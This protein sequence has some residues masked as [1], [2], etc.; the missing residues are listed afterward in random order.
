[1]MNTQQL[2]LCQIYILW[3]A[4]LK[5]ESCLT[6]VFINESST[7]LDQCSA[8]NVCKS[9]WRWRQSEALVQSWNSSLCSFTNFFFN[10]EA[11]TLTVYHSC[12]SKGYEYFTI[13]KL[14]QLKTEILR[15]TSQERLKCLTPVIHHTNVDSTSHICNS[16]SM[17]PC[18]D[19]VRELPLSY[20]F[21]G[22]MGH[23]DSCRSMPK[24][25]YD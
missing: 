8:Q 3:R 7:F 23:R 9:N 20:G 6:I 18:V 5:Q 15:Q 25:C 13:M 12:I 21:C 24:L 19:T 2:S 11:L 4:F 17:L 16:C 10:C 1:M 22:A 14:N